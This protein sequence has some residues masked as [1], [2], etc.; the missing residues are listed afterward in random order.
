MKVNGNKSGGTGIKILIIII[1]II[2]L[3][4]LYYVKYDNQHIPFSYFRINYIG[5]IFNLVISILIITG[6]MFSTFKGGKSGV[7]AL[8]TLSILMSCFLLAAWIFS[9]SHLPLPSITILNQQ[10]DKVFI[11]SLFFIFQFIQFIIL[12]AVWTNLFN[13]NAIYL[14]RSIVDSVILTIILLVLTFIFVNFNKNSD[15]KLLQSSGTN[16]GIVLGAAVWTNEPSPSLAAR[17]EKAVALYRQKKIQKI[18]LTGGNAPGELSEAEI[19][20]KYIQTKDIDTNDVWIEKNTTSTTEQIHFIKSVLKTKKDITN[21]IVISD[22]YHLARV[23]QIADFYNLRI[24]VASS[25]LDFTFENKLYYKV[26]ES[27]A[28][29][30]FW[31][32][33]I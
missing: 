27:A 3:L 9:K 23:K 4:F 15:K 16:V 11:S 14:V 29:L 28:I 20:Y 18:Q 17:V 6:L 13:K 10:I 12:I 8:L 5:N 2:D 22:S 1:T 30:I 25:D 26:R 24:L 32:F 19:A 31:F 33:A 7:Y 21:L